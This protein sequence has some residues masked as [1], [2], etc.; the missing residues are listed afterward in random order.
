MGDKANIEFA[1]FLCD[2]SEI[3]EDHSS[4]TPE[5][6]AM[7]ADSIAT[8]IDTAGPDTTKFFLRFFAGGVRTLL[9]FSGKA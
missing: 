2:L 6:T 5:A 9:K 3:I 8:L 7:F 4:M 1:R